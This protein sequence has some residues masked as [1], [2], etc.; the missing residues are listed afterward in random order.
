MGACG[1]SMISEERAEVA[2]NKEIEKQMMDAD[3]IALLRKAIE[4]LS[5]EMEQ[6]TVIMRDRKGRA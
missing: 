4:R 5:G 3:E 2:K 6:L 1:S